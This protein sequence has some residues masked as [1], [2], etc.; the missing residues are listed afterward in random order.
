M[1]TIVL[2]SLAPL[3][4]ALLVYASVRATAEHKPDADDHV[5]AVVARCRRLLHDSDPL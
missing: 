4:L 2:A 5:D 3:I 1:A